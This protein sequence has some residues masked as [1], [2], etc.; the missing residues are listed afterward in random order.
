MCE[1]AI[2]NWKFWLDAT[3]RGFSTKSF[4]YSVLIRQKHAA[5]RIRQAERVDR[6]YEIP[7]RYPLDSPSYGE[8]GLEGYTWDV[9]DFALSCK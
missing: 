1:L 6:C 2:Q 4:E 8:Y 9:L 3:G 7:K 5:E